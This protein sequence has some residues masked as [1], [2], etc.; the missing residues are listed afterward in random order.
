MVNKRWNTGKKRFDW[1][2]NLASP[3]GFLAP[4]LN[5]EEGVPTDFGEEKSY[6]PTSSDPSDRR[7]SFQLEL[8]PPSSRMADDNAQGSCGCFF[9][10]LLVLLTIGALLVVI[11]VPLGF[12][13]LE[14]YEVCAAMIF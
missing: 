3:D 7:T 6:V 1:L 8:D 14:Y 9:T 5:M 4:S 13:D 12:A 11:L 2:I 10:L